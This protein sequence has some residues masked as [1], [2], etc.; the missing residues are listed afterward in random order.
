MIEIGP[1]LQSAIIVI[2][3]TI[4][5]VVAIIATMIVMRKG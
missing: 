2:C 1:N 3:F 4:A 5:V